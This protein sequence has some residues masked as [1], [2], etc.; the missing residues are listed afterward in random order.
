MWQPMV[1]A[2]KRGFTYD[3]DIPETNLT[4]VFPCAS[5]YSPSENPPQARW[6]RR[7]MQETRGRELLELVRTL[8]KVLNNTSVILLFEFGGKK[9]LFPGD[10]QIENWS[11]SLA[12][13]EIC[14]KLRS[15]DL[16]KVGHHGSLNATPKSLWDLFTQ[17]RSSDGSAPAM[18]TVVSTLAGK[19][20][21]PED[22][23]EV[24]RIKLVS[25]LKEKSDYYSTQV[26][27]ATD[28]LF[29]NIKVL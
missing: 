14:E 13:K 23:T 22:G 2:V 17:K 20:G 8:D 7:R 28:D 25:E 6:F 10:A 11:Y 24:P 18:K 9:L 26:M 27:E 15:V 4:P 16:Y 3:G 19:H 29:H 21:H 5:Y 1:K 12:N